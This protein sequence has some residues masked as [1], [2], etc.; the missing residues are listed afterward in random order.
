MFAGLLALLEDEVEKGILAN[1]G[2]RGSSRYS[3]VLMV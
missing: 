2:L 1:G 3:D